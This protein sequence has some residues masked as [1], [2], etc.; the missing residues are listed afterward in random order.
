VF[1]IP[2]VGK[3]DLT[4]NGV[5]FVDNAALMNSISEVAESRYHTTGGVGIEIISPLR[6][7][8][9]LELA[10]AGQGQLA[11]YFTAGSRF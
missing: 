3:F 9:R 4:L 10:A 8:V 7:L 11:Y 2:W 1:D 6:D 5:C